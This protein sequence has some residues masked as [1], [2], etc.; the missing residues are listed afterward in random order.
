MLFRSTIR[1]A[2]VIFAIDG[3]RIVEHG[4][5]DELLGRGGLY[6]RLYEEQFGNGLVEAHCSDGVILA[7]GHPCRP[8]RQLRPDPSGPE[9]REPESPEPLAELPVELRTALRV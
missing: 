6:A 5:H 8:S 7:N 1:N 9:E 3:G 4:S 2:D